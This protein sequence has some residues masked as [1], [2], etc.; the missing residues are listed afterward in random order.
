M[1]SGALSARAALRIVRPGRPSRD[2]AEG[3][4]AGAARGDEAGAVVRVGEFWGELL[5]LLE[6][7]DGFADLAPHPSQELDPQIAARLDKMAR[8]KL[9]QTVSTRGRSAAASHAT[10]TTRPP[11]QGA[12][13]RQ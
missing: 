9:R 2:V 4:K 11:P 6:V 8:R 5:G 1:T 3:R 10:S 7:V 13:S 12:I